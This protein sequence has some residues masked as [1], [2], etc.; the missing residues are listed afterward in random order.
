MSAKVALDNRVATSF[1]VGSTVL[2]LTI[3]LLNQPFATV[4]AWVKGLLAA[5]IVAYVSLLVFSLAAYS[6][7]TV[8]FRPDIP[9]S[10]SHSLIYPGDLLRQWVA[11]E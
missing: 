3:G 5:A 11:D 4:D 2:P 7:W 8:D 9:V 6:L 10:R 1:G